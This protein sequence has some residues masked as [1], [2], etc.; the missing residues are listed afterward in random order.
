MYRTENL[1]FAAGL[2]MVHHLPFSPDGSLLDVTRLVCTQPETNI[3]KVI[4]QISK[5]E[6]S[7]NL[8]ALQLLIRQRSYT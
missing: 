5:P 2:L 6:G 7:E 8:Q 1:R 4:S 3:F